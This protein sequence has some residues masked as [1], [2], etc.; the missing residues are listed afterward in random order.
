MVCIVNEVLGWIYAK[1]RKVI[2]CFNFGIC[3]IISCYLLDIGD[4][5]PFS[6]FKEFENIGGSD[7]I[8]ETG[9][10][11]SGTFY[12]NDQGNNEYKTVQVVNPSKEEEA[13]EEEE[14]VPD[15][16]PIFYYRDEN[17][18][19]RYPSSPEKENSNSGRYESEPEPSK[20]EV[21]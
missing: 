20:T 13:E 5:S 21:L 4:I 17:K 16:P 19:N 8:S 15:H 14:T 6:Y 9:E 2:V 3:S 7:P 11:Y 10:V 1:I 12:Q 18:A